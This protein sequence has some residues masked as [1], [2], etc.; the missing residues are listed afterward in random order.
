MPFFIVI[1]YQFLRIVNSLAPFNAVITLFLK[2]GKDSGA[3]KKS[4]DAVAFSALCD[5]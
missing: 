5:F 1:I 4:K 3:K 2:L